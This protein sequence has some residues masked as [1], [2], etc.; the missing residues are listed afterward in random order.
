MHLDL[1]DD[2]AGALLRELD[3]SIA[4]D[5]YLLSPCITT[6]KATRRKIRPEPKRAPLLPLR[7]YEPPSK[8]R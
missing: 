4:S 7:S 5:R 3:C 2:E 8:G 1:T 6:L